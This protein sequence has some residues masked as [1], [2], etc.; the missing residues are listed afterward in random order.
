MALAMSSGLD[1]EES[2]SLAASLNSDSKVLSIKYE[3]CM[4]LLRNGSKLADAL[5]DAELMSARDSRML[6]LGDVSGMG[7]SAMAEIARRSDR[8]VQD[9]IS[10][11]VSRIEPTLVIITSVIVG[12]ILLS[13]MLPLIGIMTSIG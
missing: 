10:S 8:S 3:K 12:V 9:E 4:D 1:V 11:I 7:D 2:I 6:S 13:V 5:R